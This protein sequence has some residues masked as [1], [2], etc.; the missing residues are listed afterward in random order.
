[1]LLPRIMDPLRIDFLSALRALRSSPATAIAAVLT[2]AISVGVNLAMFDLIDRAILA[3]LLP[4]R[5]ASRTD[6]N[7]LLGAE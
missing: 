6:P 1:M 4:A 3:T 7:S 5:S 2:L